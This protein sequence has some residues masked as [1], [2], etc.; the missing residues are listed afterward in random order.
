MFDRSRNDT[1]EH[2]G[3]PVEIATDA[4][5]CMTGRLLLTIG[6]SLADV[7]NSPGQFIEFEPYGGERVFLAKASLRSIKP[8][9]VPKAPSLKGRAG[10]SDTFDPYAIL[11]LPADANH[12]QAKAAWHKLA[13]TYHPDRYASAELPPEVADYLDVMARRINA[14]YGALGAALQAVRRNSAQRSEPVYTSPAR[15]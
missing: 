4:G 1:V 12:D 9:N 11:G 7:L 3:V 6:R 15:A 13:K 2:T 8:K 14:A 10:M 5:E